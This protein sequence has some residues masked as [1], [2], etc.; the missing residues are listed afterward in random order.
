MTMANTA[1]SSSKPLLPSMIRISRRCV[2]VS[3]I[4]WVKV[5][6][7]L[8]HTRK[9]CWASCNPW[10][11]R[12]KWCWPAINH[13]SAEGCYHRFTSWALWAH[14]SLSCTSRRRTSKT[15]SRPSCWSEWRRLLRSRDAGNDMFFAFY[16]LRWRCLMT[17]DF[18]GLMGM[19]SQFT[20]KTNVSTEFYEAHIWAF[21]FGRL[22]C[23]CF[24]M[25][26]GC[27]AFIMA[28]ERYFALTK[29]F[30][31]CKHFTNGLI[32]RLILMMWT[33]CAVLSLA[34]AFGF[35]IFC[36]MNEKKCSRYRDAEAPHDVAYA[37]IFF[38]VGELNGVKLSSNWHQFSVNRNFSLHLDGADKLLS[39]AHRLPLVQQHA[40]ITVEQ[41]V[42]PQPALN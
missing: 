5:A 14:F 18:V 24:G 23:R 20:V 27:L 10:I 31:Y 40:A 32:K 29:P 42:E 17:L 8:F 39:D 41:H 9:G 36:D 2:L 1:K 11:A 7:F 6:Y 12:P 30:L 35:G 22:V 25:G 28:I 16:C 3:F 13:T 33:S 19:L 4:A 37:C 26:S 21:C 38:I 34:P 15:R